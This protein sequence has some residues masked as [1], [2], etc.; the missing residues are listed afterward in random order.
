VLIDGKTN[1]RLWGLFLMFIFLCIAVAAGSAQPIGS[2]LTGVSKA[3]IAKLMDGQDLFDDVKPASGVRFAPQSSDGDG[4]RALAAA[5]DFKLVVQS[6]FLLKGSGF[7]QG[8]RLRLFNELSRIHSLSGVTYYSESRNKT[9]ILFDDVFRVA[10]PG[11]H[12]PLPELRF[13]SVPE[14]LCMTVHVKD[15]NFGSTWYSITIGTGPTSI[16]ITM[17]NAK[18]LGFFILRAFDSGGVRM[19]FTVVPVDEGLLV[20]GVCVANPSSTAAAMVDMFSAIQKRVQAVEGWVVKR[21]EAKP[22]EGG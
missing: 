6:A 8:D 14:K 3:E 10:A 1:L 7:S 9:T 2:V 17:E 19:R 13:D 22:G 16:A 4:L 18:P 15:A 11:S 20:S 21:V 5:P 12:V